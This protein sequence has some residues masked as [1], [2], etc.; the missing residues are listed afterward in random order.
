MDNDVKID[1]IVADLEKKFNGDPNHDVAVVQEYCQTLPPCEESLKLVGALRKYAVE[2]YPD[3]EIFKISKDI[4]ERIAELEKEFNGDP[5]H[6]VKV[7]Q[8]YCAAL[9]KNQENLRI[10]IALGQYAA[11]KYPDA[12]EIKKSRTEYEKMNKEA[13]ALKLRLDDIQKMV[14]EKQYDSA[15]AAIKDILSEAKTP[16][17]DEHRFVSFTHPFEE[18]LFRATEKESRQLVRISNLVEMLNLQLGELF[19]ETKLFGEA[20]EAIQHSMELNPVSANAHLEL[21]RIAIV[22]KDFDQAYEKLLDAHHYLFTRQHLAIFYAFLAEVVENVDKNYELAVA[23]NYVSLDYAD[24]QLAHRALE[25]LAAEHKADISKPEIEKVRKLAR[26]ANLPLGPDQKI[27]ELAVTSGRQMKS[28]YPDIAKQLIQ[29]AYELT[30]Q[31]ELL[32]EIK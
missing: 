21:A 27:C 31:E 13:E 30:G 20:I 25:R 11:A 4:E 8:D 29:I 5:N 7:I 26:D 28:T 23:Y 10:V 19:A 24:N 17:D 1:R 18:I 3:A 22:R 14:H 12:D 32:K 15:I 2:K 9:P 6:D 16:D